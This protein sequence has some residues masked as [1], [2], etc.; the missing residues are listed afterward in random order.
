MNNETAPA[1]APAQ[2]QQERRTYPS[3]KTNKPRFNPHNKSSNHRQGGYRNSSKPKFVKPPVDPKAAKNKAQTLE[4]FN[5]CRKLW[6]HIFNLL[7]VKP[8][9][10]GMRQELLADAKERGI[11]VTNSTV[12]NALYWLTSTVQYKEALVAN[13]NRYNSKGVIAGAVSE[14]EKTRAQETLDSI[15]GRTKKIASIVVAKGLKKQSQNRNGRGNRPHNGNRPY[16]GN[17]PTNTNRT[18][19][20]EN[21]QNGERNNQGHRPYNNRGNNPQSR[22]DGTQHHRQQR[23]AKISYRSTK[24][25]S[26]ACSAP[27]SPAAKA[28]SASESE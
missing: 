1:P 6:P 10:V 3:E 25:R 17:R 26:A 18:N 27:T 2:P 4:S 22:S 9:C 7:K 8:V 20:G 16:N 5:Q 14:E 19:T 24:P 28:M 21:Q 15:N 23:A 13:G 12:Y 11:E